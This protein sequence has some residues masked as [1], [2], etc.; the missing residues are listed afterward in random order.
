MD[1]VPARPM[2]SLSN[3]F[4]SNPNELMGICFKD[5]LIT[6]YS[7]TTNMRGT[8][9]SLKYILAKY[10]D[11]AEIRD[12]IKVSLENMYRN[13]FENV[14]I[15]IDMEDLIDSS[16]V[17]YTINISGYQDTKQYVLSQ[18][19][20]ESNKEILNYDEVLNDLRKQLRRIE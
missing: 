4:T 10:N 12:A 7:Q 5:F 13:Y 1:F 20:T 2:L 3:T 8:I 15:I 9:S 14:M 6:D 17:K 18:I 11:K 19:I 16:T